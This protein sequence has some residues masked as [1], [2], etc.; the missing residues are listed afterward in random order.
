MPPACWNSLCRSRP[1]SAIHYKRKS[2]YNPYSLTSV[3]TS[4]F[5]LN[6]VN[7]ETGRASLMMDEW[8]GC[9]NS[10]VFCICLECMHIQ[11]MDLYSHYMYSPMY[12]PY[13]RLWLIHQWC[14]LADKGARSRNTQLDGFGK[15]WKVSCVSFIE[16][17]NYW[18]TLRFSLILTFVSIIPH[19]DLCPCKG[20]IGIE[21][22][23]FNQFHWNYGFNCR[24]TDTLI[25]CMQNVLCFYDIWHTFN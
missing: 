6:S 1:L 25:S 24:C 3:K 18:E 10:S 16:W 12:W 14:H 22:W 9:K 21:N 19:T 5:W 4:S 8:G 20:L 23:A 17:R 13:S 7:Q 15:H 11:I 2:I